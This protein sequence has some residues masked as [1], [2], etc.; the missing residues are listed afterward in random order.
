MVVRS[1][2]K[3]RKAI[4]IEVNMDV[5]GRYERADMKHAF[6]LSEPT[7][8]TIWNKSSGKDKIKC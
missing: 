5:L 6:D 7:L 8:Q 1:K 2:N 4:T 3:Q